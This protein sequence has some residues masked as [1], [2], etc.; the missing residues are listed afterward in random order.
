MG[1]VKINDSVLS[2]IG[3]AIRSKL[4]VATTY[5]PSQ[6]AAAIGTIETP[7][8]QTKSITENGTYTPGSGYNGFSQ[9]TVNVPNSYSAS[10]DGKV[11]SEGAL[12]AQ[13]SRN[14]TENGTYDTTENNEVVVSVSGGTTPTGNIN[15]TDMQVTDVSAYATAQVV[16]ADLLAGNIKKNVNILG[17]VGTY[18][19]SGSGGNNAFS[20]A[21]SAIS[22]SIMT[23]SVSAKGVTA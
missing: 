14:V 8:L 13:T 7:S 9:V 3:N 5:K 22:S 18:E 21:T 11:V 12:V 2:A 10:D 17:V 19:G 20:R 15:I 1:L 4:G 16:D 6:M 23:V